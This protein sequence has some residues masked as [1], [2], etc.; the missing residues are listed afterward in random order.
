MSA[1]ICAIS[2]GME[3]RRWADACVLCWR[4]L[5]FSWPCGWG[6][7]APYFHVQCVLPCNLIAVCIH[8]KLIAQVAQLCVCG[9]WK[10]LDGNFNVCGRVGLVFRVRGGTVS[11]AGLWKWHV[12]L[13]GL[14]CCLIHWFKKKSISK[15]IQFFFATTRFWC[16][17]LCHIHLFQQSGMFLQIQGVH[18]C[19][20]LE[21]ALTGVI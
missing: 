13:A 2:A 8:W 7:T 4:C 9:R 21:C 3:I 10:H 5:L 14:R 17:I 11:G 6:R 18:T 20:V 15:S 1:W 16:D 19:Q 12:V